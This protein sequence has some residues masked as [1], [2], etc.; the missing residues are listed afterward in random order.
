MVIRWLVLGQVRP[1]HAVEGHQVRV[2]DQRA[3]APR[4]PGQ[5]L[6]LVVADVAS[7]ALA[8]AHIPYSVASAVAIG[9]AVA[10][11]GGQAR[12]RARLA[13]QVGSC[14][15]PR[16]KGVPGAAHV[17]LDRPR[18]AVD[19]AV[20][21]AGQPRGPGILCRA[22]RLLASIGRGRA[23]W[24]VA[25]A[26]APG[27]DQR[28]VRGAEVTLP[29]EHKDP[30]LS[31]LLPGRLET[32]GER[33]RVQEEERHRLPP[34]RRGQVGHVRRVVRQVSHPGRAE[35]GAAR[36]DGLV[37]HRGV[38]VEVEQ[39]EIL[40]QHRLRVHL[41]LAAVNVEQC[42][43][44][45]GHLNGHVPTSFHESEDQVDT[46]AVLD[47]DPAHE[48]IVAVVARQGG[49]VLARCTEHQVNGLAVHLAD[50]PVPDGGLEAEV[51]PLVSQ[52]RVGHVREVEAAVASRAGVGLPAFAA[53]TPLLAAPLALRGRP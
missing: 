20:Q 23:I 22:F 49:L 32:H 44:D 40:D 35:P 43:E 24:R 21:P 18:S 7:L 25:P 37:V 6:C 51:R 11:R 26:G 5:K 13:I 2:G 19:G 45:A 16:H 50:I 31:L 33:R 8:G 34:L 36:A 10:A 30:A 48:P 38:V 29:A 3:P 52:V 27:A 4:P 39:R 28:A 9:D 53:A 41:H 46:C 1:V 47:I 15:V 42:E 12:R 17:Q 14:R